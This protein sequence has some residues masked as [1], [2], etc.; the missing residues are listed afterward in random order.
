MF[1]LPVV[2]F[3]SAPEPMAVLKTVL[4]PLISAKEP[5]AVLKLPSVLLYS[6]L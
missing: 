5:M 4:V 3:A 2:L 6:A 1:V